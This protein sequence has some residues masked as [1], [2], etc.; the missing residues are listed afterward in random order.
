M[1]LKGL[2][3]VP[4]ATGLS[5]SAPAK[6]VA[7][8]LSSSDS[9]SGSSSRS[10]SPRSRKPRSDAFDHSGRRRG[11]DLAKTYR[12]SSSEGSNSKGEHLRPKRKFKRGDRDNRRRSRSRSRGN[13][14]RS[15]Q[16]LSSD[17]EHKSSR[18]RQTARDVEFKNRR[19]ARLAI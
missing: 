7:K 9:R 1:K 10:P 14:N 17:E 12:N 6:T 4:G 2:T 8:R 13:R 19:A 18:R 15:P 3:N 16:S 5:L 11:M